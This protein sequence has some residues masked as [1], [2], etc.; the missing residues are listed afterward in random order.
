M[1]EKIGTTSR[2]DQSLKSLL[3]YRGKTP[4]IETVPGMMIKPILTLAAQ[5]NLSAFE[6]A[7]LLAERMPFLGDI[8][9]ILHRLEKFNTEKVIRDT[10]RGIVEI[11]IINPN[12]VVGG[13]AAN[14]PSEVMKNE[15]LPTPN[16]IS[17]EQ[18]GG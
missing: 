10:R 3:S 9:T 2:L 11:R 13:N 15:L 7:K 5:E 8:V 18:Q 4:G 1:S 16:N 14:T 6:L 17:H 12:E